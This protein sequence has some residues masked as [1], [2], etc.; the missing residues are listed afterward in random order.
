MIQQHNMEAD[1]T[2]VKSIYI[3]RSIKDLSTA[4]LDE[5]GR[6]GSHDS[7]DLLFTIIQFPL[8]Y[9]QFDREEDSK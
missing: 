6:N 5:K 8:N 9:I 3:V 2:D 7:Y 1:L 4:C